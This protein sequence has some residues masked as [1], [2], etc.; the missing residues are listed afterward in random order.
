MKREMRRIISS[1]IYFSKLMKL[2][3]YRAMASRPKS[4]ASCKVAMRPSKRVFLQTRLIKM[5]TTTIATRIAVIRFTL[6][7][8]EGGSRF[9]SALRSISGVLTVPVSEATVAVGS[10]LLHICGETRLACLFCVL[11]AAYLD[12]RNV[13]EEHA[14]YSLNKA[15]YRPNEMYHNGRPWVGFRYA[16]YDGNTGWMLFLALLGYS[17]PS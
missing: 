12:K 11:T 17:K 3:V 9:G 15:S 10:T 5:A 14:K 8:E 7:T 1:V 13:K 16:Q 4:S 2:R 6:R